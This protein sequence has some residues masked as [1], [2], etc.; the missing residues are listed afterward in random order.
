MTM[1]A[2][3]RPLP[4]RGLA[5]PDDPECRAFEVALGEWLADDLDR[6]SHQR[7]LQHR[8]RCADC[9]A[10]Y[11]EALVV[12]ARLARD[13]RLG[14][15]EAPADQRPRARAWRVSPFAWLGRTALPRR[16]LAS[17]VLITGIVL[18]TISW[19][20]SPASRGHLSAVTGD[21]FANGVQ[22]ASGS[23]RS[24]GNGDWCRTGPAASAELALATAQ[25]RFAPDTVGWIE[26]AETSRVRLEE[27]GLRVEGD[28][29]VTSAHGIVEISKG[30]AG[31]SVGPLGLSVQNRGGDVRVLDASGV[32]QI[33]AGEQAEL[34]FAR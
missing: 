1:T 28:C 27:G 19:S 13:A 14:R 4:I 34:A 25:V 8:A 24:V 9:N 18:A 11:R 32:R 7:M 10:R 20:A 26:D 2:G 6:A 3:E 17:V 5:F 15:N 31:V 21:V 30:L 22:I 29:V 33:P 12:V 16:K 23:T